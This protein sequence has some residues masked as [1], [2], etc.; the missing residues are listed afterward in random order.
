[1]KSF[2][3]YLNEVDSM[4]TRMKKRAAF[5]KNKAK[6][7]MKRKKAMKKAIMD[8]KKLKKK[9]NR[10]AR[11]LLIKKILKNKKY[12]DLSIGA[13]KEI[14]KRLEKKKA[15][16]QK[17]A[18]KMLPKVKSKELAKVKKRAIQKGADTIG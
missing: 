4:Q 3:E 13:K 16:I 7:L 9:A 10:A 6:I 17:I 5:R 11:N 12:Q 18:R 8:P 2:L 15:A 14:E 1:M